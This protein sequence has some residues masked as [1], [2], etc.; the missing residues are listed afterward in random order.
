MTNEKISHKIEG[1]YKKDS[2]I[3][4]YYGTIAIGEDNN[5]SGSVTIRTNEEDMKGSLEGRLE[6]LQDKNYLIFELTI[7][8]SKQY[9]LLRQQNSSK[10]KI[11]KYIGRR[12][13]IKNT[14]A[15]IKKEFLSKMHP[16]NVPKELID[17]IRGGSI[18]YLGISEHQYVWNQY[19]EKIK[20]FF[21][22]KAK[23]EDKSEC[24]N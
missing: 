8:N 6:K 18:L 13:G 21:R 7:P 12:Y 11:G 16:Q 19:K 22:K 20:N 17:Y 3:Y 10:E 5:L 1:N 4:F 24:E 9:H 14:Q 2:F 15:I 23:L